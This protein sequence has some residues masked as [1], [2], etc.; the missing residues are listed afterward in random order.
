[1]RLKGTI[2]FAHPG[3]GYGEILGEDGKTY[4]MHST[5]VRGKFKQG[6]TVLFNPPQ[7]NP[8]AEDVEVLG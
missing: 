6:D 8:R 5:E 1:M 2:T 7:R 3:G 4:F